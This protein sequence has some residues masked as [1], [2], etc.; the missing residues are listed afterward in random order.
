MTRSSSSP[1]PLHLALLCLHSSPLGR[2]GARDTGGMSV[3]VREAARH[4]ALRGHRVDVFTSPPGALRNGVQELSPGVRLV[5]LDPGAPDRAGLPE[6]VPA[7]ARRIEA[8]RR[9]AGARYDLVHSHYWISGLAGEVLARAWGVP[10][11]VTFHTLAA[12]KN[13]LACGEDEP[14]AR[15]RAEARLARTADRVTVPSRAEHEATTAVFPGLAPAR[16]PCGVD[17]GRFRPVPPAPRPRDRRVLLYVGRI[18][19]VKGLDVL[20]AAAA[21]L[22]FPWEL[23][24]V[25]GEGEPDAP[26]VRAMARA[27]GVDGRV[28]YLGPRP[29]ADLPAL[30]A[31]ADAA[32]VPSR[33]ESFGLVI[34]EALA[35]GTPVAAS[36]V[37]VAEE[38]IVPGQNGALSPPED[39]GALA[40]AIAGAA[41]LERDPDRIR[42]TV[43]GFGWAEASGRLETLYLDLLRPRT[44]R[45]AEG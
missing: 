10:H 32:V 9:R 30:Y 43:A 20:L 16:V 42:R 8:F 5:E 37:G 33:Y 19:P 28:R 24:V 18:T 39:P 44:A 13:A 41:A 6:R 23:W 35:C 40:R 12:A 21:R 11:V 25:G 22:P 36:R 7:I 14:P 31:A 45:A 26:R 29:Q 17:P 1:A 15:V 3:V 38:A 2:L 27:A 4:L 34:L